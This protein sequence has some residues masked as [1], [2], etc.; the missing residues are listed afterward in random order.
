MK[1]RPLIG[2]SMT[3]GASIRSLRSAARKVSV[4]Q[5]PCGTL[6][7][8]RLP[9]AQRP[10]LRVMLVFTQVSSMKT[11]R[12]GLSRLW[13]C[14]HRLRRRATSGRSCS[15]ACRLFFEADA[16]VLEEVPDGVIAHNHPAIGELREQRP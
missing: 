6:A 3:H 11:R 14:R 16:F 4:R 10:W 1:L 2:P 7:M 12:A 15:A 8:S 5:W 13:Y 9:L